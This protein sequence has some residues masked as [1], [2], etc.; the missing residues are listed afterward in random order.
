MHGT[1]KVYPLHETSTQGSTGPQYAQQDPWFFVHDNACSYTVNIV[2]PDQAKKGERVQIKHPPL[3]S[4]YLNLR[5]VFL[6]PQLKL[7]LK[8]NRFDVVPNFRR[9][10]TFELHSQKRLLAKLPGHA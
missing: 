4:P 5:D 1:L 6:F 3:H 7:S 9:D 10:E 8:G 2:Q